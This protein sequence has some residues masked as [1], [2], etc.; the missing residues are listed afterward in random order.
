MA[1]ELFGALLELRLL[2]I[3]A[4]NGWLVGWLAGCPYECFA[5]DEAIGFCGGLLAE[6]QIL[7]RLWLVVILLWLLLPF[8]GNNYSRR[9]QAVART[10]RERLTFL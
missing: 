6:L 10:F 4:W 3:V 1:A 2:H 9:Q 8:F 7:T 5:L